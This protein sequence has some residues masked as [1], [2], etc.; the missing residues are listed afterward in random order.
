MTALVSLGI[1][2]SVLLLYEGLTSADRPTGTSGWWLKRLQM[3]GGGA[4]SNRS[5]TEI[6][7]LLGLSVLSGTMAAGVGIAVSGS[8]VAAAIAAVLGAWLPP[9]VA[10][11]SARR[12]VRETRAAWPDALATLIASIRAGVSLPVAT[13]ELAGK[14]TPAIAPGFVAFR[15]TYRATGNFAAGLESLRTRLAD[16]I[17][18]RVAV[19][20]EIAHDVGGGDLIRVLRTLSDQIRAEIRLRA[21][22]ESRWSWTVTAARVAAAAPWIVLALMV[23]QPEGARA[24][25]SPAGSVV[26]VMGALSTFAGYRLMLRAGRLPEEKRLG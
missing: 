10:S 22:I 19:A 11:A 8:S 12:R 5:G 7:R 26:V 4:L 18:D 16:P 23:A 15:A 24:Y 14:A 2:A 1:A 6:G 13:S 17:A 3:A 20:L 21:E 9:S 25:A